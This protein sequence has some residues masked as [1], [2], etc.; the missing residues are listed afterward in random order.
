ME[1]TFAHM[2][3]NPAYALGQILRRARKQKGW[4]MA[5]LA[6]H[7]DRPREW[8]NRIELGYSTFGEYKPPSA[9]DLQAMISALNDVLD[10]PVETIFELGEQAVKEFQISRA[11]SDKAPRQGFGKLTQTEVI[12][13]EKQIVQAIVALVNEQYSDAIIRNTGIKGAGGYI[14][15]DEEWRKYRLALGEFLSKN[16]NAMFKRLEYVDSAKHLDEAK[17]AD[18]KLAGNRKLEAVHNAKIKFKQRNPLQ[19]HVLIGQR[20]AILALPHT[21]GQAGSNIALLIKD[22]IFVEAL[23]VWYDEVLWDSPGP[24][25][26][27]DFAKF[28][29]SFD[30]IR[31]I[32]GFA[33]ES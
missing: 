28:E 1:D 3:E 6:E 15:V 12:L 24:Y 14:A 22:K 10:V 25:E 9:S 19:M 7:V 18:I 21:S 5:R 13:G 8:L 31:D 26:I 2:S 16:P 30:A 4:T 20:E 17:A 11:K 27:V 23:R 29:A 32:Y 33:D